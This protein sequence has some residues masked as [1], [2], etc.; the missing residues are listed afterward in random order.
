MELEREHFSAMIL[1]VFKCGLKESHTLEL[2]TQAFG[3]LARSRA[4]VFRW[5]AEFKRGR[6]YLKYEERSG[7]PASVVTEQNIS[8]VEILIK[9][10]PRRTYK[11]IEGAPWVSSRSISTILYQHLRLRKISS[12]WVT[13]HLC[14]GLK[15][16]RVEWCTDY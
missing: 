11:D 5:F 1:Y 16:T 4:T 6:K 9:E 12:L 8:A 2:L 15:C 14:D 13:H 3:D 7:R 10:D